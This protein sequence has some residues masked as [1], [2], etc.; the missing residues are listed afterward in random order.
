MPLSPK[1]V[2]QKTFNAS[3][4]G[5][6]ED[7]VD[8][9]LEEIIASIEEYQQMVRERDA[10]IAELEAGLVMAPIAPA[11][12]AVP[13]PEPELEP[14]PEPE[15]APPPPAPV[16]IVDESA[17]SRALI[18]A[19]RTADELVDEANREAEEILEQARRQARELEEADAEHREALMDGYRRLRGELATL[20]NR[21]G[22]SFSTTEATFKSLEVEIDEFLARDVPDRA[23][24]PSEVGEIAAEAE[25]SATET[26]ERRPWERG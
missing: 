23:P 15:P 19:Q 9:F 6:A 3:F 11:P 14:E 4:R 18:V 24:N 25:N 5:Y 16:S 7:E 22:D 26:S 21:M 17:V 1:D 20:R 10:K 8:S 12:K 13:E 2:E